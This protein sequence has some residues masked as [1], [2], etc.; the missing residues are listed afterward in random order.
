[1]KLAEL[2]DPETLFTNYHNLTEQQL[3]EFLF[4]WHERGESAEELAVFL[5]Y[6]LKKEKLFQIAEPVYDCAGTGGDYANTY[7]ISTASAI[8]AAGA[9]LKIC[10]NGGRSASSSVGSV[11]VLEALGVDL[12]LPSAAKL[13]ALKKTNLA[14]MTSKKSMELLAPVKMMARKHKTTTF[15][16]LIAPFLSP[17]ELSGQ[18]IGVAQARWLE[19]MFELS[20]KMLE[21]TKRAQ[22][23]FA[24]TQ[25]SEFRLDEVTSIADSEL[26]IT[27]KQRPKKVLE[28]KLSPEKLLGLK[29]A[30]VSTLASGNKEYNAQ[31]IIDLL[32]PTENN[33]HLE[34]R[35]TLFLNTAV[36]M[37]LNAEINSEAQ[38]LDMIGKNYFKLLEFYDFG[39]LEMN[40]NKF[41]GLN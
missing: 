19:P 32:N 36:L 21:R 7:N 27:S 28:V 3:S 33:S 2:K 25:T 5:G 15:L 31:L 26:Y 14:F 13:Q 38:L 23:I 11:D 30:S 9:G 35:E 17:F 41:L 34:K 12:A 37:S 16:N 18:L 10:K 29:S 24:R 40:F 22:F 20:F 4:T 6:L 1:M 8:T 39:L